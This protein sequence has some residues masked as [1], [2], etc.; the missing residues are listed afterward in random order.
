[1]N[2][3]DSRLKDLADHNPPGSFYVVVR[4]ATVQLPGPSSSTKTTASGCGFGRYTTLDEAIA[5][6]DSL[7]AA[8]V[9]AVI[10]V[11]P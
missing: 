6:R 8:F 9:D 4:E 5:R 10:T 11:Q 2:Q 1:M 3:E 7:R